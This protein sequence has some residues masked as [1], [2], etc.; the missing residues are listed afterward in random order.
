MTRIQIENSCIFVFLF[1]LITQFVYAEG[2]GYGENLGGA[3]GDTI[4][5]DNKEDFKTYAG[6]SDPFIILVKGTIDITVESDF[7][8]VSHCRFYCDQITYHKFVTL[9]GASD[10]DISDRGKLHVTMHNNWWDTGCTSRMPRVRFAYVR[11]YNNY[12]SCDSNNYCT[13]AGI[14]GHIYSEKK[15]FDGVRDPV[16]V[17]QGG[18]V[19]TEGNEYVNCTGTIYAGNDN[20]FTP[21]YNYTALP[22]TN[23]KKMVKSN[24]CNSITDSIVNSEKK[25]T[26]ISWSDQEDI[27]LGT[28]LSQI[29]LNAIAVGNTSTPVYSYPVGTQLPESYNTITVT[30]PEDENYKAVSKTVNIKVNYVYHNL[31]VNTIDAGST[32]LINISPDGKMLL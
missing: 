26:I 2:D 25:E 12:F 20:V 22:A 30:F 3:G 5:V 28:A 19:K 4:V 32:D 21:N 6:S 13:R 10:D 31:L 27:F 11:V 15:Y 8:T 9:I 17:D 18:M 1:V 14:E 23:M 16:T 29:Q 7:V 24:A